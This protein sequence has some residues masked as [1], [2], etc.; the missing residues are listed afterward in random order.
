LD[1]GLDRVAHNIGNHTTGFGFE[2]L[3]AQIQAT[4]QNRQYVG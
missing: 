1:N 4:V 3:S 2:V